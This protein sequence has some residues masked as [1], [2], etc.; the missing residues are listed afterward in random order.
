M[1]GLMEELPLPLTACPSPWRSERSYFSHFEVLA[2]ILGAVSVSLRE[3]LE[4]D[5]FFWA[6]GVRMT[7]WRGLPGLTQS[8]NSLDWQGEVCPSIQHKFGISSN[9]KKQGTKAEGV[10]RVVDL[11]WKAQRRGSHP[12]HGAEDG[13]VGPFLCSHCPPC[14]PW[15]GTHL[16]FQTI[17]NACIQDFMYHGIHL[18]RRSPVHTK[19]RE[20][21]R[22]QEHWSCIFNN[23]P[24]VFLDSCL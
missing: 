5:P 4:T 10:V 6:T 17:E 11:N 18:P 12:L 22:T 19:V 8:Q 23:A 24:P 21:S 3:A 15:E 13:W 2:P 1:P 9:Q 14:H 7:Q 20:V 16:L